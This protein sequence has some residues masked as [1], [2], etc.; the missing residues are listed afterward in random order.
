MQIS[1]WRH[2]VKKQNDHLTFTEQQR[3]HC[4]FER[5]CMKKMA[6]VEGR[7]LRSV[8]TEKTR[9]NTLISK[10]PL[11]IYHNILFVVALTAEVVQILEEV[12]YFKSPA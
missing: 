6:A 12:W 8:R 7:S 3:N 4:L 5:L 9:K 11:R 10:E 2:L 1:R